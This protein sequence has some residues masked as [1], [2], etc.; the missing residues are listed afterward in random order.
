MNL[1]PTQK[2]HLAPCR[3][4][5]QEQVQLSTSRPLR[6]ETVSV[7]DSV[8]PHD[9]DYY[10]ICL[11]H[12]GTA[13]HQTEHYERPLAPGSVII[14]APGQTHAF[15]KA[16]GLTVTN[17]Y[18]L[19]EWL[20][21]DLRTFWDQDGL[22]Q[23]FM[24]A[25]LFRRPMTDVPVPQISMNALEMKSCCA[26]IEDSRR[27]LGT[28]APSTVL[29]K[30]SLLKFMITICRA[31][32][33]EEPARQLGFGFRREVWA[34]LEAIEDAI[35]QSQPFVV[36][37]MASECGL[38]TD[39]LGHVFKQAVGYAP[40]DYFQRRRIQHACTWLLNPRHSITDVALTLGFSD[41]AHFSRLFRRYH[42]NSPREY[43]K[44]YSTVSRVTLQSSPQR[45]Q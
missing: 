41:A 12:Q 18:Y 30:S 45:R 15:Q 34:T 31:Y 42:G 13:L 36:E 43:R 29:L 23:L 44:M 11:V 21:S 3:T 17:I 10:E 14:M 1:V 24:A 7:H 26:E 27:E 5:R 6:L 33:R 16:R 22:L 35:R 32:A 37:A 9:H 40:M 20:L 8:A 19:T 4:I 39:H 28:A 38:S 2:S 25:R